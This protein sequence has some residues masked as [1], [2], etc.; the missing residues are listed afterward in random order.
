MCNM[1][2]AM[3]STSGW[4]QCVSISMRCS[5]LIMCAYWMSTGI[6]WFCDIAAA[7]TTAI[8]YIIG[9]MRFFHEW[10]CFC[11]LLQ[12]SSYTVAINWE[13]KNHSYDSWT[14]SLSNICFVQIERISSR[15]KVN[16]NF[17]ASAAA[18]LHAIPQDRHIDN[19]VR[20]LNSLLRTTWTLHCNASAE[21][22]KTQQSQIIRFN[23]TFFHVPNMVPQSHSIHIN[24]QRIN[25][26]K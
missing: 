10:N 15:R 26:F 16:A 9:M 25:V 7:A 17:D 18:A 14:I 22:E 12:L 21:I 2:Y 3:W 20:T 11:W 24:V 13:S 8:I 1:Q 19:N 4:L 5:A 23:H 6:I